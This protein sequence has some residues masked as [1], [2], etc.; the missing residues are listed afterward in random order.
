MKLCLNHPAVV[1]F[2]ANWVRR[3][4]RVGFAPVADVK[5]RVLARADGQDKIE[6]IGLSGVGFEMSAGEASINE[7]GKFY[8][9]TTFVESTGGDRD[10]IV[11]GLDVRGRISASWTAI[12]APA[13]ARTSVVYL[14]EGFSGV[15]SSSRTVAERILIHE[16]EYDPRESQISREELRIE[17]VEGAYIINGEPFNKIMIGFKYLERSLRPASLTYA[18]FDYL[19]Y[20][21]STPSEMLVS[22]T[23]LEDDE[24][25]CIGPAAKCWRKSR[26][27]ITPGEIWVSLRPTDIPHGVIVKSGV[28]E[29]H[30]AAI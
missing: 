20:P 15:E 19:G 8:A 5:Y 10:L 25:P 21:V 29:I 13:V 27:S 17:T 2:N 26:S 14:N 11:N 3:S 16:E 6:K 12:Q 28:S 18:W 1:T 7:S 4:H 23:G 30:Q 9:A 22:D 24:R